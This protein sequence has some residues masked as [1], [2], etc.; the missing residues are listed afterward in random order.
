MDIRIPRAGAAAMAI[1]LAAFLAVLV[2]RAQVGRFEGLL[3]LAIATGLLAW[4]Y[5]RSPVFLARESEDE[6]AEEPASRARMLG[7]L[8]VGLLG[9]LV[10]A[11][12]V[13]RGVRGLLDTLPISETF[14]GMVVIGMGESVEEV[15]R[16]VTPARRGH[17]EIAWGNV[18][19]T[20]VILLG[21]N[22]GVIALAA[23]VAVDPRVRSLHVPYLAAVVLVVA[24]ALGRARRLGR[25][26]G[27][28]LLG[29]YVVYLALN[30]WNELR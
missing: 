7:L 29:L 14:L 11:E 19:G 16:M 4:L 30:V 13:V 17:P 12:L 1:S 9:M 20:V 10:G 26:M 25:G 5:R 23:P 2:N 6:D 21:I 24:G 22:L 8:M 28:L 3:L 27:G 18:V 15:A